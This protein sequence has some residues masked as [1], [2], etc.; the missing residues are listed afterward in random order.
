MTK[1]FVNT[2]FKGSKIQDGGEGKVKN[3]Q[4]KKIELQLKQLDSSMKY[5]M[6]KYIQ[7]GGS[8]KTNR[9][10]TSFVTKILK[11][12]PKITKK[13]LNTALMIS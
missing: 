8:L 10:I 12:S 3:K 7:G 6:K 13:I 1:Y 5:Q 2:S 11:N 4:S 9:E